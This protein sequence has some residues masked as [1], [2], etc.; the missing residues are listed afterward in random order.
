MPII[1][2]DKSVFQEIENVIERRDKMY[3]DQIATTKKLTDSIEKVYEQEVKKLRNQLQQKENIIKEAIE[4]HDNCVNN[5]L[6]LD[7]IEENER[8]AY[9]VAYEIHDNYLKILKGE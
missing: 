5:L 7:K 6:D 9:K 1:E 4:Y 3:E 2:I 8:L